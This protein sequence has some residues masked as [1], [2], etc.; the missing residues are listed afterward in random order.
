MDIHDSAAGRLHCPHCLLVAF[1]VRI[2]RKNMSLVLSLQCYT[3]VV[4]GEYIDL[5]I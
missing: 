3:I 4:H 2:S 5:I 1:L